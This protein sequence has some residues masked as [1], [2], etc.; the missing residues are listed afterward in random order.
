MEQGNAPDV[1]V[2][3]V[4]GDILAALADDDGNFALIVERWV[5]F[6]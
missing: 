1:F 5:R 4:R 3:P 2:D 6:G